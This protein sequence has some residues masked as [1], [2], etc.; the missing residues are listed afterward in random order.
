[1]VEEV[2]EIGGGIILI[3]K[4]NGDVVPEMRAYLKKIE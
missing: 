3:K 1:M 2:R 4:K